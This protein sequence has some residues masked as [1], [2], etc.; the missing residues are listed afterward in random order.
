MERSGEGGRRMLADLLD[1]SHLM[2]IESLPDKAA[3]CARAASFREVLIY[4][5]DLQRTTLRLVSGDEAAA[6]GHEPELPIEGTVAGRAY[7]YGDVLPA[8]P[9]GGVYPWWVPLLDGTER[10][11]LLRVT[12]EHNDA[13]ARA[14]MEALAALVSLVLVSKQA[15]GKD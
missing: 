12:S 13:A 9:P 7:Q 11:G 1:A 8:A 4:V 2:P 5:A 6:Q 3:E 14:D 10:I 15:T